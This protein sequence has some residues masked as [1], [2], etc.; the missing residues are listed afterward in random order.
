MRYN[1]DMSEVGGGLEPKLQ[2]DITSGQ[3]F[4]EVN[5]IKT[6]YIE[7][8]NPNG[9]RFMYIGGW[10]SSAAGD[11][12]FLDGLE[13]KIPGSVGFNNL[14]ESK[15]ESA[16]SLA[17]NVRGLE[18]KY[19][20][21][22]LELPGFG[23]SDALKGKVNLDRMADFVADFQEVIGLKG[24][25][26]F[27]S[28]MGALVAVKIAAK[29]PEMVKALMLQGVMTEKDDMDKMA[30]K[31]AKISTHPLIS[32]IL[33]IPYVS[34]SIYELFM[35][36]SSDFKASSKDAQKAM[37]EGVRKAHKKTATSTLREVGK[38]ISEDIAKVQC[39]VIIVDGASAKTVPLIKQKEAA[40]KFHRVFPQDPSQRMTRTDQG[41]TLSISDDFGEQGHTVVNTCP[42]ALAV[43]VDKM[44]TRLLKEQAKP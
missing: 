31:A 4:V 16:K 37:V 23:N 25:C 5:G 32:P 7:R 35:K 12:W 15:P 20:I 11:K 26:I 33:R 8:G 22:D 24:A 28:S 30:Y 18:G 2:K 9:K 1:K 43:L 3:K 36:T 39:P 44:S 27:G 29:H 38:D 6:S 13:G 17:T 10:A 14:L 34:S 21:I 19:R 40:G 41:V 42:E